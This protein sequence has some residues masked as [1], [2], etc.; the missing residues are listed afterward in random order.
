M[1]DTFPD[2]QAQLITSLEQLT[3]Q[4]DAMHLAQLTSLAFDLPKLYF[5]R[6]YLDLDEKDAIHLC[7]QRLQDGVNNQKF[8]LEYLIQLLSVKDYFDSEDARLRLA[9]EPLDAEEDK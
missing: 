6:E 2:N 4:L 8:T 7:Q 9:P 3:T 1:S 5:C